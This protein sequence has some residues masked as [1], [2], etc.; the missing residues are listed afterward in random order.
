MTQ[1]GNAI[2]L[3]A[4][5]LALGVAVGFGAAELLSPAARGPAEPARGSVAQIPARDMQDG[6]APGTSGADEIATAL[7]DLRRTLAALQSVLERNAAAPAPAP[8]RRPVGGAEPAPD[9]RELAASIESLA[10]ALRAMP[11]GRSSDAG[12]ALVIPGWVDREAAFDTAA[13]RQLY[14]TDEEGE[15][16]E[17]AARA[18]SAKHLFWTRQD[19]LD[20]YGKP[21]D[22]YRDDGFLVWRFHIAGDREWEDFDFRFDGG[23]VARVDYEYDWEGE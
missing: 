23:S 9:S 8:D 6:S 3:A 22:V 12:D 19:V 5:G 18:W 7:V 2:P 16:A 4:A 10:R 11:A 15:R 13:L 21:D 17:A 1:H 20:R 14:R